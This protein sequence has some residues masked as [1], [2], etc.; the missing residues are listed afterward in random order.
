MHVH[1]VACVYVNVPGYRTGPHYEQLH[2]SSGKTPNANSSTNKI[3]VKFIGFVND[4][5]HAGV[6]NVR[7]VY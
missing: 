3:Y 7:R 6:R 1:S 2:G 4:D 5:T